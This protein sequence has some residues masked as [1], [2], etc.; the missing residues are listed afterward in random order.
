MNLYLD[1]DCA[2]RLLARLLRT[3]AHDVQTPADIGL[4]GATDAVHLRHALRENRVFLTRNYDDF[5]DLH[6]LVLEARGHHPGILVI[7]QDR[8]PKHNLRGADIVR[9]IAKLL[10]AGAPLADQY[11]ILNHWR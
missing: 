3:A 2:G 5:E 9:A 10:A 6:E 11:I 4:A 8:N 7:R 1:D